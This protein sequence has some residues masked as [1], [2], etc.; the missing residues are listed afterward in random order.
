PICPPARFPAVKWSAPPPSAATHQN[1]HDDEDDER[2]REPPLLAQLFRR[3]HIRQRDLAPLGAPR[4]DAPRRRENPLAVVAPP[5]FRDHVFANGL[6]G[7][8]VGDE[9][10]E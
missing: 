1:Q 4:D 6:T 3:W 9:L 5:E 7:E 8:A 10:L 2:E